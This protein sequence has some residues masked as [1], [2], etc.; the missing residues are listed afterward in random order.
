MILLVDQGNS[1]LKWLLVD[2]GG[3]AKY[4]GVGGQEDLALALGGA[5]PSGRA[6]LVEEVHV[7]SVAGAGQREALRQLVIE[8][9]HSEPLFASSSKREGGIRNGY[10]DPSRLGVD[11]WLAMV[12]ARTHGNGPSLVVDAGTAL[13]I[14]AIALDGEHLGGYIVPGIRSQCLSLGKHTAAVRTKG[15]IG[16]ASGWGRTTDEAVTGGILLSL[17]ALIERARV[18]LE[19]SVADTCP[20]IL[21]GGDSDLLRGALSGQVIVDGCLLFRGLWVSSCPG[22]PVLQA[23]EDVE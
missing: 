1:R 10:K 21:T 2:R 18:E 3:V 9:C 11:R 6:G 17:V 13:T 5:G 19:S 8:R 14:D 15:R 22:R 7:S 23:G 12:G 20:V 4:K 16:P